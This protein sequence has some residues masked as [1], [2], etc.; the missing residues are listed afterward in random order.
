AEECYEGN[1]GL[2]GLFGDPSGLFALRVRGDS[3]VDAGILEGDY[4]IVRQQENADAGEI[5]VALV[6][7]EATVKYLRPAE[8]RV[9]L[10]AANAKYD[11]IVVQEGGDFRILGVVSGVIRIVG[12]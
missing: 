7:D 11:P 2:G 12:T 4:V 8:G 10:L 5:V 9:E 6:G 3:M 1:L